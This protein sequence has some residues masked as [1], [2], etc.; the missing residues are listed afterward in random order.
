[1]ID[2]AIYEL[3]NLNALV[4]TNIGNDVYLGVVPESVN[5]NAIR[6]VVS[7]NPSEFDGG[8]IEAKQKAN[9]QIDTFINNYTLN[10]TLSRSLH[11]QLH[12]FKGVQGAINISLLEVL[13]SDLTY[14]SKT[15]E[16]R[17]T[18][19]LNVTYTET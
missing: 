12:G 17:T 16:H 1:M 7:D 13:D 14:D 2:Q 3:I 15:R 10:R 6:F 5:G 11:K 18:L 8:G 4:Q 9:V 19:T